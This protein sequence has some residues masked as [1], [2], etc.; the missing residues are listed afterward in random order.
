M[1]GRSIKKVDGSLKEVVLEAKARRKY[2]KST[3]IKL[4]EN[5]LANIEKVKEKYGLTLQDIIDVI[6]EFNIPDKLFENISEY[7]RR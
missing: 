7:I 6:F 4:S 1:G 2:Y 5:A 3:S